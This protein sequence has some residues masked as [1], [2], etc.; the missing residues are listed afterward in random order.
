MDIRNYFKVAEGDKKEENE[1]H[2][3]SNCEDKKLFSD[4]VSSSAIYTSYENTFDDR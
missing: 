2:E 4:I 1:T 3:T